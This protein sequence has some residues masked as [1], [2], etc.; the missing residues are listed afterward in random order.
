MDNGTMNAQ[1]IHAKFV[2]YEAWSQSASGQQYLINLYERHGATSP[3]PTFRLLVVARSRTGLDDDGRLSE[4][5]TATNR[6]PA[7]LR[8]RFWLTTVAALREHQQDDHPLDAYVWL[9]PGDPHGPTEPRRR[10]LF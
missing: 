10:R 3:R 5:L 7:S 4:L 9:R 6:A 2:R 8:R 1:Q